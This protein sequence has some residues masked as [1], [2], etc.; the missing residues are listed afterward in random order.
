[1]EGLDAQFV[2]PSYSSVLGL[3]EW[4]GAQKRGSK[5][6]RKISSN[7]MEPVLNAGKQI[8]NWFTDLV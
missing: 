4:V 6:K 2:H 5:M 1:M 8:K 3:V 7:M